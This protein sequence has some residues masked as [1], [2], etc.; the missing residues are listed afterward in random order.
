MAA[1]VADWLGFGVAV[2]VSAWR[3]DDAGLGTCVALGFGFAGVFFAGFGFGVCLAGFGFADFDV[4][5]FGF[6]G[7]EVARFGFGGLEVAG[8]GFVDFDAVGLGV[9]GF[10]VV[11]FA[12]FEAA[13][14]AWRVVVG[15]G[16]GFED[17][18]G[19]GDG[20]ALVGEEVGVTRVATVALEGAV[21]DAPAAA[22]PV[23]AT[24]NAPEAAITS[25]IADTIAVLAARPF[26]PD[27]PA[28]R[29]GVWLAKLH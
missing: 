10:A 3:L 19:D 1:A 5:G 14:V 26:R 6:G 13:G 28:R 21:V 17:G 20:V 29:G 22:E 11:G 8:F 16:F 25:G 23:P 27:P 18:D 12:L 7:L 9:V 24:A 15:F 2:G 4:V